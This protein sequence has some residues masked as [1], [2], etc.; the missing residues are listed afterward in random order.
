MGLGGTG[1]LGLQEKS[2]RAERRCQSR[3]KVLQGYPITEPFQSVEAV[4]DY[5]SGDRV[6]CLICGKS[7]KALGIHIEKIHGI[8]VD[9]Y[10]ERYNIPWTYGLVCAES[11]GNYSTATRRRMDDGWQPPAKTGDAHRVLVGA[12]KRK[13]KFKGEIAKKN[14]GDRLLPKRPLAIAPDGSVETFTQQRERLSAK[15]GTEQFKQKMRNRP[16][17]KERGIALGRAWR[18]KKQSPDHLLNR[19]KAIHGAEWEPKT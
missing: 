8:T 10:R 9:G 7:Y 17:M 4:R 1:Y 16:G 5:L 2:L 15:R 18:G 13:T 11:S 19:M 3:R 14:L 6:I 12:P